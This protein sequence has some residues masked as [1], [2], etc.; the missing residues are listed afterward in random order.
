MLNLSPIFALDQACERSLAQLEAATLRVG[1]AAR[2]DDNMETTEQRPRGPVRA[3]DPKIACI[4]SILPVSS[5][6]SEH[7][8]TNRILSTRVDILSGHSYICQ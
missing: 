8:P 6:S 5:L 2:L 4:L 1:L 3:R 7:H